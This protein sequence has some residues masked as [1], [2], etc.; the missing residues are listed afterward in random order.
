MSTPQDGET[1]RPPTHRA[2]EARRGYD[3]HNRMLQ[4][5]IRTALDTV[6][7]DARILAMPPGED[8]RPRTDTAGLLKAAQTLGHYLPLLVRALSEDQ[9]LQE[10]ATYLLPDAPQDSAR[11]RD[12]DR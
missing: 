5:N 9:A 12:G 10:A 2:Y 8:G 4:A 3:H 11:T 7:P 1:A 6:R